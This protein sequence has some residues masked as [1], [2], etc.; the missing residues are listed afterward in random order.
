MLHRE[1]REKERESG[2]QVF[3][4]EVERVRLLKLAVDS[5]FD[6]EL[7]KQCLDL[8]INVYGTRS[9]SNLFFS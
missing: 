9:F 5:G 2:S 4:M 6:E 3:E 7:A 8:L 1:G